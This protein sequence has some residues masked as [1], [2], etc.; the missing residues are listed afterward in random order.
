M[1]NILLLCLVCLMFMGCHKQVQVA[2]P[3]P[4]V[5][6]TQPLVQDTQ[7]YNQ[8]VGHVEA[9]EKVDIQAQVEGVL[10]SYFFTEGQTVKK[11]DL[12]FKIDSRPY[13]AQLKK[14]EGALAESIA[15]LR[16]AED[17][18][19]R[20]TKLAEADY[21]SKL[22]YDQF[23][24]NVLTSKGAIIQNKADI[25]TANIN[26]SYCNIHAPINGIT[27]VLKLDVGNLITNAEQTPLVT[28][29]NIRPCYA[30][31]SVPQKDLPKIM[32]L[33]KK[34]TLTVQALQS[35]G[36]TFT[37]M[38][39]LIDNQINKNT[40]SI[41]LR[42]VFP[43]EEELL[44][45]GEFVNIHLLLETEKQAMLIPTEAVNLGDKG[46]YVFIIDSDNTAKLRYVE[47]GKTF[48]EMT[49][50]TKGIE[51]KEW[52]VTKGQIALRPNAKVTVKKRGAS[53]P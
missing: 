1:K 42:G 28:L 37:G 21:V 8:Y 39:D 31:F 2:P 16:Y 3:L 32:E 27:G 36:P 22:Q 52:V 26:I 13:E 15:G 49:L 35:D 33:H 11:G 44:W 41:S 23:L 7:I 30:Y 48:G 51:P 18:V 29:M 40:G 17:V 19:K 9:F 4:Q 10:L 38:L 53:T 14:A 5:E 24:T 25:D 50:I 20:N 43:N 12:L 6:V 47:T 34:G 46:K 45:P